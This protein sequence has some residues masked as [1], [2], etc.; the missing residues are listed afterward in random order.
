MTQPEAQLHQVAFDKKL[1]SVWADTDHRY[2]N[3]PIVYV[4]DGS[5]SVYVGESL[6]VA[7]RFRQHLDTDSKKSL[8][9]ARVVVD[10]TFN[11]SVCLDLESWL[12]QMFGGDGVLKVL[13]RNEGITNTNYYDRD[14]YQARFQDVFTSLKEAGLFRKSIAEIQNSS[15]FKLSPFKALTEDQRISVSEIV[16]S[17]FADLDEGGRSLTV[18]QG[19]PGTGKT[20]VAIYLMKLLAD[21]KSSAADE[22]Q[23]DVGLFSDFFTEGYAEQLADFTFGIVIPQQALR[24]SVKGVFKKVPGL[25]PAMV[26]DPFGV[27]SRMTHFDLLIVDE[28]H[29]LSQRAS[30]SSGPQNKRYGEINKSMFG[31]DSYERTQ[32]DW[33][34][35]R[36]DHQILLVDAKQSVRPGDLPR[37]LIDTVIQN[38]TTR[39]RFF[40]LKTQ[41]RV[42]AGDDYVGYIRSVLAGEAPQPRSF[43]SY[44]LRFFDDVAEMESAIRAKE[45]TYGLSRLVAGYAW[46]WASKADPK[47]WDIA[48]GPHQYRWNTTL[49]DWIASPSSIDEVGSIH[50]TQGYDLNYAGVIIGADLRYDPVTKRMAF[51]RAN[52]FDAR[53]KAN[54]GMLGITYT[55]DEILEYIRNIYAVLL[56]RGILGTFVYACDPGL[57]EYLR[58]YFS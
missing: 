29:R 31:E 50:T 41:H 43:P 42:T 30:Q 2:R 33:I 1:V 11:K 57:R 58:T 23:D 48:I 25:D 22:P 54:N 20:V 45:A 6:N 34:R 24:K 36:S 15:L 44:D 18:I 40:R 35:A 53:G 55:D 12:I 7:T 8:T 13:N 4:L 26:L 49:V 10:D 14:A 28:A 21:I 51:D 16:D 3:W 5:K 19:E 9:T 39:G 46:K 37:T 38:A 32:L 27:G 56:T 52:Y 47:A 17:L